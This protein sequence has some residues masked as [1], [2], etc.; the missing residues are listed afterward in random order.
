L[1]TVLT[2]GIIQTNSIEKWVVLKAIEY[3]EW[4]LEYSIEHRLTEL[5]KNE[6]KK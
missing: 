5:I 6:S 2:L 1:I 3:A 4:T